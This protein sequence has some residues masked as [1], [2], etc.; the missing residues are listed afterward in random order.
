MTASLTWLDKVPLGTKDASNWPDQP[1]SD[2]KVILK[3]SAAR[4]RWF[5][6][7]AAGNRL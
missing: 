4:K 7:K 6:T 3:V 5:C 1:Q 2:R